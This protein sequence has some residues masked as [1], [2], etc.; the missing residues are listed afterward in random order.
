MTV[1]LVLFCMSWLCF[2]EDMRAGGKCFQGDMFSG[3]IARREGMRNKVPPI[4]REGP[5][6]G[7]STTPMLSPC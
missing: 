3:G 7:V 1:V 6:R 5:G 4:C 2:E